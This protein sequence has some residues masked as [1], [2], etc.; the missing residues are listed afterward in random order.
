MYFDLIGQHG[1]AWLLRVAA[2]SNYFLNTNRL[3]IGLHLEKL[4]WG[5]LFYL[6]QF[7]SST[8][9]EMKENITNT[10]EIRAKSLIFN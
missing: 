6:Y 8:V 1:V 3:L 5:S 2:T 10:A 4:I 9:L 7:I